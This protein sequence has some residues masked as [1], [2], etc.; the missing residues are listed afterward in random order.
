MTPALPEISNVT[1]ND[2]D[3]TPP[4]LSSST[5]SDGATAVGVSSNI[6]LTFSENIAAG[7][8]NIVISDGASDTRTI[9]VGDAQISI[10]GATLTINPTADLNSSTGYYVQVASTAVDDL[11]SNSYAG[12]SDTTTLNFTTADVVSPTLSSSTPSDGATA[13]GVSSNI[14]LTFSEN[15]A[16]G[17]GNIVISDGASDTRTIP[18]GDAQI[19]ISGATLT[20]NPTADL[21]SSTGYYVQVASTAVDDLSSN[22]YAGI[23]DT[24]TLNFTTADVVSPT[25]SSS[26][27]SDGATAVGVSSNIV[28]T[29]SEN[30]AAGTGNIVISDQ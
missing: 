7:T 2:A 25:L 15:I 11:S 23:S 28:L 6:V 10:S 30:I 27:P 5:P 13:V 20:I 4:T 21:N 1:I 19:S 12:I 8:G 18:V 29:F 16:A 22:S 3:I 17:T 24:T 14:V 26:T 9:P